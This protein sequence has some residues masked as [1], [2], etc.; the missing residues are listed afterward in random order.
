M[1][2]HPCPL[3]KEE[4]EREEE[5]EKGKKRRGGG[6]RGGGDGGGS[7]FPTSQRK[8]GERREAQPWSC[9]HPQARAVLPRLKRR[10]HETLPD[11][12]L[13][14]SPCS[15]L[16]HTGQQPAHLRYLPESLPISLPQSFLSLMAHSQRVSKTCLNQGKGFAW[17]LTPSIP[18][19]LCT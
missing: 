7:N 9:P 18:C 17:P 14:Q 15:F 13:V 11:F 1:L 6:G 2:P 8:G 5:E 4:E 10:G 19:A 16:S 3:Q 12:T